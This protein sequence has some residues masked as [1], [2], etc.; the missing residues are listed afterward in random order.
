VFDEIAFARL[1]SLIP[2]PPR[3]AR[4]IADRKPLDVAFV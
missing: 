1:G 2:R 3:L 4:D